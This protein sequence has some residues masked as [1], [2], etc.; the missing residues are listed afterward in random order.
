MHACLLPYWELHI[1]ATLDWTIFKELL[2]FSTDYFIKSFD[3]TIFEGVIPPFV[4]L[5]INVSFCIDLKSKMSDSGGHCLILGPNQNK[6]KSKL[7]KLYIII[8]NFYKVWT[9]LLKFKLYLKSTTWT[10]IL[11]WWIYIR[12]KNIIVKVRFTLAKRFFFCFVCFFF[13]FQ[14]W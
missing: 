10:F 4:I 2:P 11:S 12:K 8:V 5:S 1:V 9:N 13:S 14:F 3:W 7:M 6:M